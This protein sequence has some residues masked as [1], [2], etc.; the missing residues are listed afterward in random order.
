M[1]KNFIDR[2]TD[3]QKQN[4]DFII[5]TCLKNGITNPYTIAAILA[6]S[7]KE[8]QLIPITE[9]SYENT[10]N[11][12][13][14]RIFSA[15]NYPKLHALSKAQLTALKK[16]PEDFFNLLYGGRYENGEKEGYK[17]RGRG[18]VQHTFKYSYRKIGEK[19]GEDYVNNPDLLNEPK[20]A[21][22]GLVWYMTDANRF[23]NPNETIGINDAAEKVYM[24]VRGWGNGKPTASSLGWKQVQT[25][26]PI[27]EE[28]VKKKINELQTN[29]TTPQNSKLRRA[30]LIGLIFAAGYFVYKYY[31]KQENV[32]NLPPVN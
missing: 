8:T 11:S 28:Y 12:D 17:Y 19:Y 31:N 22:N 3:K 18:F 6:V 7:N 32:E 15:K 30:L 9:R 25:E 27:F 4:A 10:D 29:T 16:K 14:L 23:F 1:D 2:L 5:E 13:I 26:A 20:G 21:A 24:H